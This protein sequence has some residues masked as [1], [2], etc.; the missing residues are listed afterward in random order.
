MSKIERA[1]KDLLDASKKF[2]EAVNNLYWAQNP[3]DFESSAGVPPSEG[4]AIDTQHEAYI[5]LESA[6]YYME[7]ALK[8]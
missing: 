7:K 4:E 6:E 3:E 5:G 2:R 8:K 1:A